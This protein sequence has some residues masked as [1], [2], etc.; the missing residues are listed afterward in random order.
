MK[1][2]ITNECGR[3]WQEFNSFDSAWDFIERFIPKE[4]R[5]KLY[6][7]GENEIKYL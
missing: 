4:V 5:M 1:Y 3:Y 2:F 6:V 7:V